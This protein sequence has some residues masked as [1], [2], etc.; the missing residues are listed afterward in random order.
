MR[1]AF[2]TRPL[3]LSAV[4]L[5]ACDDP[6][7][8][9][10]DDVALRP[11][12]GY[13][14]TL[15][16]LNSPTVNDAIVT[17]LHLDGQPNAGGV[18]LVSVRDKSTGLNYRPDIDPRDELLARNDFSVRATAREL[19]RDRKQISRWIARYAIALPNR[20]EPDDD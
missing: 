4:L 11:G 13:G 14:C 18:R 12:G 8:L 2:S 19:D 17:E 6:G 1:R 9:A 5:S 10:P 7:E 3:V 20:P 16:S 15:C